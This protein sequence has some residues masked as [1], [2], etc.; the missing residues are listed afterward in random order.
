MDQATYDTLT[1]LPNRFLLQD[2]IAQFIGG[3]SRRKSK[4]AVLL[5]DLDCLKLVNEN[6]GY[7]VGDALLQ[8]VARRLESCVRE[9]DI[10]ARWG[11]DEFVIVLSD[12]EHQEEIIP[13]I[14]RCQETLSEAFKIDRQEIQIAS[15][16]G[17]SI[18]PKDGKDVK[19]LLK[20]ANSALY[21][22]KEEG[23]NCF[24][25]YKV[26]RKARV[27]ALE[28]KVLKPKGIPSLEKPNNV[29]PLKP[30]R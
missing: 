9:A 4:A 5:I 19:T 2:R 26:S 21:D 30:R 28:K 1:Q 3:G 17:I 20:N 15:S 24:S 25:F 7:K 14:E 10:L 22:A 12:I 13:I 6:L 16:I 18:F 27:V 29:I 23:L 8:S 11:G